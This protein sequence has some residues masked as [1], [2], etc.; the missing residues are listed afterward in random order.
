MTQDLL[1]GLVA[2]A[3]GAGLL[4]VGLP[5]RQ[6]ESPRFLQSYAAPMLYPAAIL[7]DFLPLGSSS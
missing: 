6:G 4:V 3:L 5:N 2:V 7:I 1:I